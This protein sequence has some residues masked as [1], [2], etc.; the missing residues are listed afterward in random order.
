MLSPLETPTGYSGESGVTAALFLTFDRDMDTA[1]K[2]AYS[3]FLCR[4]AGVIKSVVDETWMD[5]RVLRLLLAATDTN[6]TGEVTYTAGAIKLQTAGGI[7]I[8]GSFGPVT[9]PA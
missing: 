2:P 7:Q 6:S 8:Y 5:A 9:C 1:S 3:D 4:Y